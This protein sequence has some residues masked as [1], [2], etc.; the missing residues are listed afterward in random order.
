M[1]VERAIELQAHCWQLQADGKFAEASAACGQALRLIEEA[2]GSTSPDVA[3]LLNDL[4]EIELDRRDFPVARTLIE[5]ALSVEHQLG[6]RLDGDAG[7]RIRMRTLAIG[8]TL[9]R[10]EGDYRGAEPE[11]RG[12]LTIAIDTFGDAAQ[13]TAEARSNLE[14]LYK[15]SGRFDEGVQ[16]YTR[17]LASIVAIHGEESLDAGV[18]YHNIGGILHAR[19][20]FTQAESPA[21]RAWDIS[22]CAL[23]EDDPRTMMD[24]VGLCGNSRWPGTV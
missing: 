12:A 4:A 3:N 23:G 14:V 6:D 18:V 17:A 16:L 20:D 22:R 1:S 8:G 5:R 7:A 21:R 15:Y 19:G 10:L 2:D 11:L 9:R 13:E 24:A